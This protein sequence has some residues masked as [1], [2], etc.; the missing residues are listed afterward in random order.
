MT[1]KTE[2]EYQTEIT[3]LNNQIKILYHTIDTLNLDSYSRTYN[4]LKVI[5]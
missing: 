2:L 1:K 4:P 5:K 3:N